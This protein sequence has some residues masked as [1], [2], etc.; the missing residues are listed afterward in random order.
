VADHVHF[1]EG[2]DKPTRVAAWADVMRVMGPSIQKLNGLPARFRVNAF[3]NPEQ[4]VA[5]G[6]KIE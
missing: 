3:P 6:A 2:Q 5:M 1:Y 4:M